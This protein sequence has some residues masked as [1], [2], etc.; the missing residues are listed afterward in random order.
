MTTLDNTN[1]G[2]RNKKR[3]THIKRK[4]YITYNKNIHTTIT[5]QTHE[6]PPKLKIK[7]E[8]TNTSNKQ[9]EDAETKP[10]CKPIALENKTTQHQNANRKVLY[11][12]LGR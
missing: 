6:T 1:E 12:S 3:K 4:N 8:D 2:D 9:H 11:E 7:Q 10:T 5:S